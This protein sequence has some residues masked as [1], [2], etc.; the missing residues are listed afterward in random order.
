MN[1]SELMGVVGGIIAAGSDQSKRAQGSLDSVIDILEGSV[2]RE[3]S[4]FNLFEVG[5]GSGCLD[6]FQVNHIQGYR[7]CA[8]NKERL[9]TSRKAGAVLEVAA[10][11]NDEDGVSF[12]TGKISEL[13]DLLKSSRSVFER[14]LFSFE[15]DGKRGGIGKV[16]LYG[17]IRSKDEARALCRLLGF[18]PDEDIIK[19]IL[20]DLFNIGVDFLPDGSCRLKIYKRWPLK[21]ASFDTHAAKA[22]LEPLHAMFPLQDYAVMLRL[23]PDGKI[24]RPIKWG[25]NFCHTTKV[26]ELACASPLRS[27]FKNFFSFASAHCP[28]LDIS[29]LVFEGKFMGLY[30]GRRLGGW[31]VSAGEVERRSS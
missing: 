27:K 8:E 9:L 11:I 10:K 15:F 7:N 28:D 18:R 2:S 31:L 26:W 21:A 3:Q 1:K 22:L 4:A 20:N 17:Y 24:K 5:I 12:A 6:R 29:Y 14:V 16:T 30:C 13:L 19:L 25:V 23:G